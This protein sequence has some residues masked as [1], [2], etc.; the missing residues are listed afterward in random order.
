MLC[1]RAVY[2][3][4]CKFIFVYGVCS[5]ILL[6]HVRQSDVWQTRGEEV[7]RVH[8]WSKRVW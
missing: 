7:E 5:G 4:K 8:A 3:K 1:A 6:L 2:I